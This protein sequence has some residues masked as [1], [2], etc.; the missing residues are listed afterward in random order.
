MKTVSVRVIV[1]ASALL[2]LLAALFVPMQPVLAAPPTPD[3][4]NLEIMLQRERLALQNQQRRI[5]LANQ[6]IEQTQT[7]IDHQKA[8]GQDTS[9]L[10]SA[11]AAFRAAVQ[12]TQ[13]DNNSAAALLATPAGFDDNGKVTDGAQ[14]RQTIR[15][16]GQELR[17][18]HLS[19]TAA[20]L[21][22]RL[23]IR[24]Y[25]DSLNSL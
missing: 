14:A 25:A 24:S 11:L 16:A 5:D 9:S 22:F 4:A 17:S 8:N 15:Q 3:Y 20:T 6:S 23:A 12:E 18:A 2:A 7:F 10:E 21:D 1:I 13:G 19:I